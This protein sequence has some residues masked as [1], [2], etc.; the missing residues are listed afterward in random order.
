MPSGAPEVIAAGGL[1]DVAA[2]FA[3]HCAPQLPVGWSGVRSGPVHR[4]GRHDR[5]PAHRPR[6]AHRPA[7]PDRRP[8]ARARPG[9]R[10]RAVAAG[11]AARRP[12]RRVHGVGRG[13]RRRGGQRDPDRG[14]ARGHL[15]VLT[16]TPG[17]R[18]PSWSPSW[19]TTSSPDRRRAEVTYT[20]GVPPVVNDRLATAIIAGAAGAALGPDR[21]VEAEISMGGED[22]AF[23]LEHVP[24]SMIRLGVGVPGSD[25]S[26]TSTSAASTSTS[27]RS[28]TASGSWCTP[29]SPRSPRGRSESPRRKPHE[30]V[31]GTRR[32]IRR[33][34]DWPG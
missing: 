4:R 7:A 33:P 28:A 12:R 13:A 15:R 10:R 16:A 18:C 6:R 32:R 30:S 31:G 2:I 34:A 24:G 1:K 22:F 26:A 11:P 8:R 21:V 5:G 20:R 25:R 23:Y 17:A 14:E 27:A 3:L 9:D 19:S 29:P